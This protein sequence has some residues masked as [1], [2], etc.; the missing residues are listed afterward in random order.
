LYFLPLPH[1]QGSLRPTFGCVRTTVALSGWLAFASGEEPADWDAPPKEDMLLWF[2]DW[3]V[4][5]ERLAGLRSPPSA[6]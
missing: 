4:P 6:I 2:A 1:G 5:I 3:I